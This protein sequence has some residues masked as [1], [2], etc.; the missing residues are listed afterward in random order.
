MK[1]CTH[2]QS[3]SLILEIHINGIIQCIIF[4]DWILLF[5]M[6]LR[7]IHFEACINISFSFTNSILP[8]WQTTLCLTFLSADRHLVA[9]VNNAT[10]NTCEQVFELTYVFFLF[11]LGK[12]PS[13][14]ITGP[15]DNYV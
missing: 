13:S 7:Y 2:L 9:N 8:Y 15:Y 14:G 11:F 12:I 1:P 6:S 5:N 10:M 3:L 4:C